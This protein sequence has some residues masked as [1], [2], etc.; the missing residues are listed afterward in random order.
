MFFVVEILLEFSKTL[1]DC[2]QNVV[3]ILA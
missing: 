2:G 3:V 1:A